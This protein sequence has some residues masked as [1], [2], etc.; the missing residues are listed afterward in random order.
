MTG[1]ASSNEKPDTGIDLDLKVGT[2]VGFNGETLRGLDLRVSRRAGVITHLALN[3]KLG[4]DAPLTGDLRG[5]G[6]SGRQ[7]VV[8][9]N[10]AG[11]FFRFTDIYQKIAGGEIGVAL[12]P[13]SAALAPQEGLLN[14]RDFVVRGGRGP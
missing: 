1:P 5:R 8:E 2:V 7:V 10:D 6:S 3:A 11:A 9:T 12:D 14:L 13:Q 4:R